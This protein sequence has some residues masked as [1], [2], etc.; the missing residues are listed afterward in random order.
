MTKQK[1]GYLIGWSLLL[2]LLIVVSSVVSPVTSY[3]DSAYTGQ[4]QTQLVKGTKLSLSVEDSGGWKSV[5]K[6]GVEQTPLP[7]IAE[8]MA[9]QLNLDWN[10]P[11]AS[12]SQMTE[13]DYFVFN[14]PSYFEFENTEEHPI[15]DQTKSEIL[16][17]FKIQDSKIMARLTN[18]GLNKEGIT[19]G[20]ISVKGRVSSPG[21]QL[22]FEV[23]NGVTIPPLTIEPGDDS[24]I[25]GNGLTTPIVKDGFQVR[26]ENQIT[27]P[28]YI[29]Y[30][31]EAKRFVGDSFVSHKS[32][33][34]VDKLEDGTTLNNMQLN[35]SAQVALD[36][37]EMSN[38]HVFFPVTNTKELTP[39][40]NESLN[41]FK[42]RLQAN[43]PMS[44]GVVDNTVVYYL[45][46][47]PSSNVQLA[48]TWKADLQGEL[49]DL[50]SKGTIDQT[51]YDKTMAYYSKLS[52]WMN[53][54]IVIT[55]DVKNSSRSISNTAKMESTDGNS[56]SNL[57]KVDY[58]NVR[59]SAIGLDPGKVK[60]VK[61]DDAGN[62]LQ[63]VTF[64]LQKKDAQGTFE[65]Y[66]APD[67]GALIR[68]TDQDGTILF[69][70]LEYGDYQI[71]EVQGLPNYGL[72]QYTS[73][74]QFSVGSSDTQGTEVEVVDSRPTTTNMSV[75][76]VWDD[77]NNRDG[78]RPDSVQMQLYADD[79]ASGDPVTLNEAN[80]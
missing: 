18:T 75:K 34:I 21:S 60:I 71:K 74:N 68:S 16:G 27:W 59:G 19:D 8:G 25:V 20:L 54:N 80:K 32:V 3:A 65:D 37:G 24:G 26:N 33:F 6:N 50:M 49:D 4:D 78:T 62:A 39:Q 1:K 44:Y 15:Y 14:L 31:Q 28:L 72:P 17:Y 45:G 29:N 53:F 73:G 9:V 51:E 52:S 64:K 47:L 69:S 10:V 22:Q 13:S 43:G 79:K 67:G 46:N 5:I 7:N 58:Q 42:G 57:V 38:Y 55:V 63:G 66:T 40:A 48:S 11:K 35:V 36:S 2:A 61:K 70:D 56:G 12:L 77:Y 23:T 76:K 41:A 30:D